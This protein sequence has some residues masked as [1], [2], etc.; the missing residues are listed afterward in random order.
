MFLSVCVDYNGRRISPMFWI[1]SKTTTT[2][3]IMNSILSALHNCRI[4]FHVF[5]A[6][7]HC[8]NSN[9]L[10]TVAHT[11]QDIIVGEVFRTFVHSILSTA[12]A[13]VLF[14]A[15]SNTCLSISFGYLDW[16]HVS[17]MK[18]LVDVHICVAFHLLLSIGN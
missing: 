8:Y 5:I 18:L 1:H 15:A 6:K 14:V 2:V 17:E 7:E 16:M 11:C 13:V 4:I 12:Y 3:L 9:S 10:F